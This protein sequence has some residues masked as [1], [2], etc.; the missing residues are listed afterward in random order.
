M[1]TTIITG[2]LFAAL[3]AAAVTPVP[4]AEKVM[5]QHLA[6]QAEVTF[7][8]VKIKAVAFEISGRDIDSE[9]CTAENPDFPKPKE[10]AP[11][12][13]PGFRFTLH[14][15]VTRNEFGI[16]L[17]YEPS[18]GIE[19][20][21]FGNVPTTCRV[22]DERPGHLVCTQAGGARS[23]ALDGSSPPPEQ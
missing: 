21:G 23:L 4:N 5:I 6:V 16:H 20:H 2:S 14:R 12:S 10:I 17:Y 1:R 15:G 7:H 9:M 22:I 11:C 8:V 19:Y 3:A 18:T 13:T